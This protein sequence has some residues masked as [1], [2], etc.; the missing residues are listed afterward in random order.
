MLLAIHLKVFTE[1]ILLLKY[2]LFYI[3]LIAYF[4]YNPQ[5]NSPIF[6][7]F[8]NFWTRNARKHSTPLKTRRTTWFP[9]KFQ[10]KKL[11]LGVGTQGMTILSKYA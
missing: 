8:F 5:R 3:I 9:T 4:I 10:V 1:E 6:C 11:A 7:F 2:C